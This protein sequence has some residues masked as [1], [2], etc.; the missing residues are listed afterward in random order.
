MARKSRKMVNA[1]TDSTIFGEGAVKTAQERAA[2]QKE[3]KHKKRIAQKEKRRQ[4]CKE[5]LDRLLPVQTRKATLITLAVIGVFVAGCG[6]L[7]GLQ[8]R[9]DN[10]DP[11]EGRT[12][13]ADHTDLPE[14]ADSGMTAVVN[15]IYYTKNGGLYVLL[16]VRNNNDTTDTVSKLHFKLYNEKDEVIAATTTTDVPD[17]FYII[18]GKIKD[19]ELFIPEKYVKI[20]DDSLSVIAYE[21]NIE[22]EVYTK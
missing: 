3:E 22:S 16:N 6:I 19:L 11:I 15:E 21:L 9:K 14:Q 10:W 12:Y 7:M 8:I 5:A 2:L 4:M 1:D 20:P 18:A 17:D 13:F